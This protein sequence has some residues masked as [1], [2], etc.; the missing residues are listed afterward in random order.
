MNPYECELLSEESARLNTLGI[1]YKHIMISDG[2]PIVIVP[3]DVMSVII[4]E[5]DT[6]KKLPGL[7]V[8]ENGCKWTA[9][10]IVHGKHEHRSG[11]TE[12]KAF[13]WT[14]GYPIGESERRSRYAG[15]TPYTRSRK[16][17]RR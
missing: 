4:S 15:Q 14:L 3:H 16:K 12:C 10:R 5:R 13:R 2:K 7:F 8:S 1:P 9:S 11:L 6:G 17:K